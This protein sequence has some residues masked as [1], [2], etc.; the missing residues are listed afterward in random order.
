MRYNV[1]I[2]P[3]S[4]IELYDLSAD[5][6]ETKNLAEQYPEIAAELSN[7]MARARSGTQI[8]TLI[9]QI[10]DTFRAIRWAVKNKFLFNEVG[11]ASSNFVQPLPP[12]AASSTRLPNILWIVAEDLSPFFG[13]YGD[14]VNQGHTPTVDRLAA[15]GVLLSVLMRFRQYVRLA[16]LP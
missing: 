8:Q 3:D 10:D 14:H 12:M 16:G 5:L 2:S 11:R 9:S 13:C 7:L 4:P 1:S 6:G 15:D